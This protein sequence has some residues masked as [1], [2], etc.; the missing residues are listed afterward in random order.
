MEVVKNLQASLPFT[1]LVTQVSAYAKFLKEI[2]TKKKTFN[3]V[4]TV[5]FIA[6]CNAALQANL[7]PILKDPGS[8]SIPYHI[9]SIA[10]DKALCD[11]G[12]SVSVMPYSICQKVNMGQLR[13]TNMI[14]QMADRSLKR[15]LGVL[16]DVP[17]RVGKY[18]IPVDFIVMGMAEDS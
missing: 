5:A 17:V 7:P 10:I 3:E 18:F 11:L 2:L 9:G 8:F 15:P 1:K 16:E 4:E 12:D 14:L 13:V 6:E